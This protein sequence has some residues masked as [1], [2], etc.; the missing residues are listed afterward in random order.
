M[1]TS[2]DTG[3]TGNT[4]M[5]WDVRTA[6]H[7]DAHRGALV[8]DGRVVA[9]CG[10]SFTPQPDLFEPGP[11]WLRSP[12]DPARCCSTCLTA[13]ASAA[14]DHRAAGELAALALAN[15]DGVHGC[16][17]SPHDAPE[18][19]CPADGVTAPARRL[20]PACWT[21]PP[22]PFSAQSDRN[23]RSG[24]PWRVVGLRELLREAPREAGEFSL[25]GPS[26]LPPRLEQGIRP[27][28]DLARASGRAPITPEYG[29]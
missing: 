27:D 16:I 3:D 29:R 1:T 5:R 25:P 19:C 17:D 24:D 26:P 6:G 21:R 13:S 9:L 8:M 23:Y 28:R 18:P 7:R 15:L 2:S 20:R 12:A 14:D 10:V 4:S 22:R 11:L